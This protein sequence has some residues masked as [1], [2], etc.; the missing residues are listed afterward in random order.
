MFATRVGIDPGKTGAIALIEDGVVAAV[1]DM[2][3]DAAGLYRLLHR[4][5]PIYAEYVVEKVHAMPRNGVKMG[6]QSS[7]TF[8][9]GCGVI[10]GVLASLELTFKYATPQL[11]KRRAGLIGEEKK[12][13]LA[14]AR[15]RHPE[16]KAWLTRV[17]DIGRA[18]AILIAEFGGSNG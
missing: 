10:E 5:Y 7:F 12:A 3:A 17:K 2:P 18:E 4:D 6:A 1:D 8:G 9:F 14:L 11:W 16:A 15:E 13:S